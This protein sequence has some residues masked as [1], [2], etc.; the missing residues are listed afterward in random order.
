M[1]FTMVQLLLLLMYWNLWWL[2]CHSNVFPIFLFPYFSGFVDWLYQYLSH[3]NVFL[4]SRERYIPIQIQFQDP[5]FLIKPKCFGIIYVKCVFFLCVVCSV[6][7]KITLCNKR[8]VSGSIWNVENCERC[9]ILESAY[10]PIARIVF[11]FRNILLGCNESHV[12][13]LVNALLVFF[14]FYLIY[15]LTGRCMNNTPVD[16]FYTHLIYSRI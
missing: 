3:F 14:L 12:F 6:I 9:P 1:I 4:F 10:F 13:D 7:F 5:S 15:M 2:P 11:D 16:Y 8:N